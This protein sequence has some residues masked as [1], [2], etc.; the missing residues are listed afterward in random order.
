MGHNPGRLSEKLPI[1]AYTKKTALRRYGRGAVSYAGE[2]RLAWRHKPLGQGPEDGQAGAQEGVVEAIA[3]GVKAG[4][5]FPGAQAQ[6]K[7]REGP[8]EMAEILRPT[9]GSV[10]EPGG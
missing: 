7:A 6:K 1:L 8:Q 9:H 2:R 10:Q 3:G 4:L 5:T